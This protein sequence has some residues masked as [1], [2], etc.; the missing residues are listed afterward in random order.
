MGNFVAVCL[1]SLPLTALAADA[2]ALQNP[3][4]EVPAGCV[5][6][7]PVNLG[8]TRLGVPSAGNTFCHASRV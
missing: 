6:G 7:S 8:A 5:G 3:A 2:F 1:A 4:T